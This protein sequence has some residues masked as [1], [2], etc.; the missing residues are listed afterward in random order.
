ME[1]YKFIPEVGKKIFTHDIDD[2]QK[3]DLLHEEVNK[4]DLPAHL[5]IDVNQDIVTLDGNVLDTAVKEKI[6]ITLGNIEG[7]STVQEN[8]SVATETEKSQFFTVKTGDTLWKIA[9]EIYGDGSQYHLI[10]DA[11]RMILENANALFAGQKLR[12][13]FLGSLET[14]E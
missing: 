13:P 8:L 7:I 6:L 3:K 14:A 12:I 9:E 2:I 11:N 1:S 4:L 10:F 5:S